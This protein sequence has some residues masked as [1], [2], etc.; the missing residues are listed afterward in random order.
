MSHPITV[1]R[2]TFELTLDE[3]KHEFDTKHRL[4]KGIEHPDVFDA[5]VERNL[6]VAAFDAAV[7]AVAQAMK[8]LEAER[9]LSVIKAAGLKYK[10]TQWEIREDGSRWVEWATVEVAPASHNRA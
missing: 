9:I 7:E 2:N 6:R 8:T 1:A 4:Q 3:L 10:P 5:N